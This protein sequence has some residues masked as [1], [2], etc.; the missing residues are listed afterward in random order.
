[1]ISQLHPDNFQ[2]HDISEL[3]GNEC[4]SPVNSLLTLT[5]ESRMVLLENTTPSLNS[6]RVEFYLIQGL[7]EFI[8]YPL[9]RQVAQLWVNRT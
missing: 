7:L 2:K 9:G 3:I 1:M 4:L 5:K 6:I 8:Q